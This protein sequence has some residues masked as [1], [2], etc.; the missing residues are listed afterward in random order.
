VRAA[1]WTAPAALC[2]LLVT[3]CGRGGAAAPPTTT[4]TVFAA[5]S[6]TESFTELGRLY[7]QERPGTTVAFSFAGSQTLAAQLEQ[8]APADLLATADE[9]TAAKVAA[10]LDPLR[11]LAHNRLALVTPPGDPAGVTTLADLGRPGL[12]VVLAGP[13]VPAGAAARRAL[14]AAHVQVSP[15]SEELD[16][17]GVVTKVRLGEADAGIA[18]ATDLR[19]A[20]ASVAGTELPGVAATYPAAVVRGSGRADAARAFLDL[21]T[22]ARGQAVLARYGFLPA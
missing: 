3:A 12:R 13:T 16:V 20:G 7:E 4:L 22:S 17:K 2:L 6:L 21:V 1:R 18:Y 19:A 8:G 5:A 14:S 11:V 15:V 9:A 10:R